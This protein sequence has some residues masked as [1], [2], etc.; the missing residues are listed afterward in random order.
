MSLSAAEF[1][2][3]FH[4]PERIEWVRYLRCA[5]GR[6]HGPCENHH[7]RT[8]QNSGTG[9]KPG[10]EFIIP[11]HPACHEEYHDHGRETFEEKYGVNCL[12]YAARVQAAWVAL[13]PSQRTAA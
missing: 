10:Y 9:Y 8:S 13:N 5:C 12:E 2:R 7:V 6:P 11:L 4:S 1:R 3:Q